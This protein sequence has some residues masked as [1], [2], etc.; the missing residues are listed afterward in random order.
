MIPVLVNL[1]GS[2]VTSR[3]A[4][5]LVLFA[6]EEKNDGS[7]MEIGGATVTIARNVK[8]GTVVIRKAAAD[9]KIVEGM[10]YSYTILGTV[11]KI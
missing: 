10:T 3:H 1:C 4:V 9:C 7:N 2:I 11:K 8:K 6:T 5:M